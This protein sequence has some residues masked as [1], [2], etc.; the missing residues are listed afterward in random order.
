MFSLL[1]HFVCTTVIDIIT[2]W[3]TVM[4]LAWPIG[5]LNLTTS[6]RLIKLAFFK[7]CS[8]LSRPSVGHER[9]LLPVRLLL[10]LLLHSISAATMRTLISCSIF[11]REAVLLKPSRRRH[12]VCRAVMALALVA[13]LVMPTQALSHALATQPHEGS[14]AHSDALADGTTGP[15]LC[16]SNPSAFRNLMRREGRPNQQGTG[17]G[18]GDSTSFAC[19]SG[20][21]VPA[22]TQLDDQTRDSRHDEPES[23]GPD[24]GRASP[25][26]FR[27]LS[28]GVSS[29]LMAAAGR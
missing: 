3:K 18:Q 20:V 27:K 7:L 10:G 21:Y 2:D 8:L 17:T 12:G 26:L 9:F 1:W 6:L 5:K 24:D 13:T 11:D 28:L 4:K 23:A 15:P 16:K 25:D 22:A 19:G 29:R 14:S